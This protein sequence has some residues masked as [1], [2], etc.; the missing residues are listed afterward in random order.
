[1]CV[2]DGDEAVWDGLAAHSELVRINYCKSVL[3]PGDNINYMSNLDVVF[4]ICL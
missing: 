4:T 3:A 2:F 1:M